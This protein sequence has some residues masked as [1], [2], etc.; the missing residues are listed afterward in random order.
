MS[1]VKHGSCLCGAVKFT[2]TLKDTRVSACHCG[3]CRKWGG[4][5]LFVADCAEPIRFT[6]GQPMIFDSSDWAQRGFCGQCGTHLLYQLKVGNFVNVPVGVLEDD[7]WVF[8]MQVY[9]DHKPAYY[10]FSNQ[11][12]QMTGAEVEALFS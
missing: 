12:K 5:P 2:V 8:D 4:G 6:A 10:C 3:M 1:L 11:T 9:V 7:E